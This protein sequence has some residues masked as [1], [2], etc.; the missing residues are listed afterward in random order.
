[1]LGV[2]SNPTR[3]RGTQLKAKPTEKGE[4]GVGTSFPMRGGQFPVFLLAGEK[5]RTVARFL[6]LSRMKKRRR[7]NVMGRVKGKRWD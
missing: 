3:C 7:G 1:M 6:S 5:K 2:D 4:N